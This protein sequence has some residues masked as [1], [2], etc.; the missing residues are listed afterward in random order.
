MLWAH[1][2]ARRLP[3][4]ALAGWAFCPPMPMGSCRAACVSMGI[5]LDALITTF[6]LPVTADDI[7]RQKLRAGLA[8]LASLAEQVEGAFR[9]LLDRGEGRKGGEWLQRRQEAQ[10]A[11]QSLCACRALAVESEWAA[12][13]RSQPAAVA[14]ERVLAPAAGGSTAHGAGVWCPCGR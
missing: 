6:V 9:G 1:A 14:R 4:K 5:A 12:L 8:A 7:M 13:G 11:S 3:Q 10:G 2:R